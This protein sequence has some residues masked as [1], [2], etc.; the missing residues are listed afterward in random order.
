MTRSSLNDFLENHKNLENLDREK[1]ESVF[2]GTCTMIAKGI[3][4]RAF[5]L[6][7]AVN[8][9]LVDSVMVGVATRLDSGPITKPDKLGDAFEQLI[10]DEDFQRAVGRATADEERVRARFSKAEAAFAAVE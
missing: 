10:A 6:T 3:G 2:A 9:A 4:Q 1:V 7:T 5:R 8:A